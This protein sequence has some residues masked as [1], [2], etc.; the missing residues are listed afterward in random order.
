MS[1]RSAWEALCHRP[2]EVQVGSTTLTLHRQQGRWGASSDTVD[3][4]LSAAADVPRRV[5]G[6]AAWWD[7]H[8]A[9]M[10]AAAIAELGEAGT[11]PRLRVSSQRATQVAW[12][13]GRSEATDHELAAA[14]AGAAAALQRAMTTQRA[15]GRS[16][17]MHDDPD[18]APIALERLAW[19]LAKPIWRRAGLGLPATLPD[20]G[21]A[22]HQT[23]RVA[24]RQ[25]GDVPLPAVLDLVLAF[26]LG[27]RDTRGQPVPSFRFDQG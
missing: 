1:R 8:R 12:R 11:H 18:A 14:H 5:D 21:R 16:L 9:R 6:V 3:A 7:A 24:L 19:G 13:H 26:W 2:T 22:A 23:A 25:R 27:G 17:L 20:A 10:L 15:L 4:L